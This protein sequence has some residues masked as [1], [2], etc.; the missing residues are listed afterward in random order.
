MNEAD[1][2]VKRTR[3]LLQDAFMA[4]MAE[5]SFHA[6]S[7]QDIAE[8]ATVN[9]ATFY[10][11]FEDKYALLDQVV[12]E[13]FQKML[14]SRVS[15]ASPFTLSNLHLLIVTV[16]EGL[17]GFHAH[18]KPTYR[19]LDSRIETKVQQELHK[20]LMGWLGQLSPGEAEQRA[21]RETVATVMSWAIFGVGVKWSRG[22]KTVSADEM[23]RQVLDLL[24]G[25]LERVVKMP[26]QAR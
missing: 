12:G 17:A 8:R 11:H 7:V 10:A 18:C 24:T 20:F 23:A 6:I 26:S 14:N 16:F 13:W 21:T 22:A 19:D 9:R 15:A 3:K 25:G 5:K 4:L 2:R 1:P